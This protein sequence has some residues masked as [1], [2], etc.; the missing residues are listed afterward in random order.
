[1]SIFGVFLVRMFPHLDLDWIRRDIS[2]RMR[3]NMDQKN[4][5]YRH[6]TR[7][8]WSKKSPFNPFMRNVVK[9]MAK[10][11]LKIW[12]C[13]HRK[14]FNICW[15][16][17]QHYAWD[18]YGHWSHHKETNWLISFTM[19]LVDWFFIQ[20]SHLIIRLGMPCYNNLF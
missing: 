19:T 8:K 17:F 9:W 13:L 6:F 1:M 14:N 11:T 12:R 16:I 10:Q 2:I 18:G 3:G 7:H 4:S 5:E 15:A 20:L